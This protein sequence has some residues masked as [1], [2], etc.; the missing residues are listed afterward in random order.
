MKKLY[1]LLLIC[2]IGT[3]SCENKEPKD[4]QIIASNLLKNGSADTK[5]LVGEWELIKFAY[6]TDGNK[7]SDIATISDVAVG[8]TTL[9]YIDIT[10][11]DEEYISY[12]CELEPK[13]C[14][15]N[16]SSIFNFSFCYHFLFY[17]ISENL[18][19]FITSQFPFMINIILTDDGNDVLNALKNAYSFVIRGDEL[20]I[21]FTGVK[22]KNLLILK[23]ILV[24]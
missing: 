2:F 7:I 20:I 6:T 11:P 22:N 12:F 18:T 14:S 10:A 19:G 1:F 21:Y 9:N 4:K 24:L 15:Y 16:L 5:L 8:F 3:V 13:L 23:K 17:S